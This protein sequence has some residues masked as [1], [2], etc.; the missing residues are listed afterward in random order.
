MSRTIYEPLTNA[1][2]DRAY[3]NS[4]KVH[5]EGPHGVRVPVRE[6]VLSGDEPPLSAPT[7]ITVGFM[8]FS[9]DMPT[10]AAPHPGSSSRQAISLATGFTTPMRARP[11]PQS[12]S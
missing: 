12:C 6:I 7:R 5:V 4:R 8:N 9:L 1:D 2:F 3:P 10:K 11:Y